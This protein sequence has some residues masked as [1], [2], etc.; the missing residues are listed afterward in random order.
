MCAR[1]RLLLPEK[2]GVLDA[3]DLQ[4]LLSC[5]STAPNPVPLASASITKGLEKLGSAKTGH[6]VMMTFMLEN[7][8]SC[9]T[10]QVN[11]SFFRASYSGLQIVP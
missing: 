4:G 7:A 9:A 8:C 5:I 3:A 1:M 10:P 11:W 2:M 6:D